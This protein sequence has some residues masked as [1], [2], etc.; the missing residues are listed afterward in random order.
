MW[1]SERFADS[2]KGLSWKN[3]WKHFNDQYEHWPL[4]TTF[5]NLLFEKLLRTLK[6]LPDIPICSSLNAVL[7]QMLWIYLK[8]LLSLQGQ[9]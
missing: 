2:Y 3:M 5:S 7:H 4:S 1:S 8:S 6:R 9:N